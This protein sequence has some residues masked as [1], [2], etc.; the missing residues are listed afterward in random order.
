MK[1]SSGVPS[2]V[3]SPLKA[4]MESIFF[5]M[6]RRAIVR[7]VCVNHSVRYLT[8]SAWGTI[9][10]RARAVSRVNIFVSQV[11]MACL[12]SLCENSNLDNM[13]PI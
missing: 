13:M 3:R 5:Y 6:G 9:R 1:K 7:H 4:L 10:R 11:T 8:S 2:L 12:I